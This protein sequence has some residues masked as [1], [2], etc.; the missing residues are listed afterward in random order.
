[1]NFQFGVGVIGKIKMECKVKRYLIMLVLF[2][3][4]CAGN[5]GIQIDR[6][7]KREMHEKIFE[8]MDL[9]FDTFPIVK[10]G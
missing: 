6:S 2:A 4:G 3:N 7:E 5:V 8:D 9:I 10:K 1:M